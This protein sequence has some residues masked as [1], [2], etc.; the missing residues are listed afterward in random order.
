MRVIRGLEA[1]PPG[2]GPVCL[3]LGTFDGLHR[4]HQAVVHAVRAGATAIGGQAVVVTLDPHPLVIVSPPK[5]PYLLSTIDER[6]HLF[7]RTGIDALVVVRFDEAIRQLPAI[8]WLDAL[9]RHLRPRHIV[10]SS[11][12]AFGRDREGTPVYLQAW[13]AEREI[14]VTI[15]PPVRNGGVAIS[16]SAVR[17][18]L[19]AGDVRTAADWLGRWYAVS[20]EVV[21][22]EGRG[23][24]L[25]APTA[26]LRVVPEKI[27]P[28]RG[29]YAAYATVEA[30]THKAAVNIGIRPTFGGGDALVE[31][32]LIDT[33][34]AIRSKILEI[35]F[36]QRLRD[37]MRFPNADTLRDQI[38]LDVDRARRLLDLESG[39]ARN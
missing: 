12:H 17:E 6:I 28:Q 36:V 9:V 37:E 15:V 24:D 1:F 16:S 8:R 30:Q 39:Y 33:T 14:Q 20:G 38:A 21:A 7:E 26:N 10:A 18:R 2:S 35:A 19:R 34:A 31:A 11:T 4:G 13:A 32:H 25:G 3:A 29:V 27:V 23:R 22:G 5:E